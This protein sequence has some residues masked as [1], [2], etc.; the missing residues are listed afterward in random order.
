MSRRK[1]TRA[2]K[3]QHSQVFRVRQ[4]GGNEIEWDGMHEGDRMLLRRRM[5]ASSSYREPDNWATQ[6]LLLWTITSISSRV[7]LE[8]QVKMK[9]A[10]PSVLL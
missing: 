5:G 7:H 2:K 3:S 4:N 6:G 10:A 1:G 9:V 8:L